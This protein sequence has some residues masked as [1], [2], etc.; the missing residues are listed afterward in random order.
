MLQFQHSEVTGSAHR[1]PKTSNHQTNHRYHSK[2][3]L[4]SA[5]GAQKGTAAQG[6][7]NNEDECVLLTKSVCPVH[8]TEHR[9]P[10]KW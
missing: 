3:A 10:F 7:K 9:N 8:V 6:E 4:S 2:P 5:A 1:N